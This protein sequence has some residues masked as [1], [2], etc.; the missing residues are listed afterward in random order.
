M[1]WWIIAET[2]TGSLPDFVQ[3]GVL[4]LVICAF[5]AGWIWPKPPVDRLLKDKESAEAQRNALVE[6]YEKVV[7]PAIQQ[8]NTMV[9]PAL[10][11]LA[12]ALR[13]VKEQLQALQVQVAGLR[14]DG[15][16]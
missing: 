5:L 13:E 9:L 10:T 8:M 16:S 4:G 11:E 12:V 6:T 14:S 2:G 15:T 3:Y 7:I 1:P